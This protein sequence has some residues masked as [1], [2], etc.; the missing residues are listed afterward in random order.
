M[1][2]Y[3]MEV[4]VIALL[5]TPAATAALLDRPPTC[6][7]SHNTG[8][9]LGSAKVGLMR[10][11]CWKWRWRNLCWW[12]IMGT[13]LR[14]HDDVAEWVSSWAPKFRIQSEACIKINTIQRSLL[15][16]IQ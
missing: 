6:G 15:H 1:Q 9:P 14:W 11:S 16:G 5:R 2:Y 7:V 13:A 8:E 12:R 4:F 3:Q 10:Q